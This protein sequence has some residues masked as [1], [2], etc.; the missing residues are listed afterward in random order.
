MQQNFLTFQMFQNQLLLLKNTV[1]VKKRDL[2]SDCVISL[3]EI[4]GT[5]VIPL[6]KIPTGTYVDDLS[7]YL[8]FKDKEG[9]HF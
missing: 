3:G 8:V 4:W 6:D 1:T 7:D 2:A 5:T 9:N